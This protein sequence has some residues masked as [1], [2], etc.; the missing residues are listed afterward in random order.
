MNTSRLVVI[1]V[2]GLVGISVPGPGVLAQSTSTVMPGDGVT[3]Q[4]ITP[5]GRVITQSVSSDGRI[6]TQNITPTGMVLS[7]GVETDSKKTDRRSDAPS[8][9]KVGLDV[10]AWDASQRGPLL[11]VAPEAVIPAW[12]TVMRK[13]QFGPDGSPLPFT[14]V[15]SRPPELLSGG[16][17]RVPDLADYF[18]HRLVRLRGLSVLAPTKMVI[19]NTKFGKPDYFADLP[20]QGK[21]QMLQASLNAAQWRQ[22]GSESG[23]GASDLSRNQRELY[24]SFLPNPMVICTPGV[25][26]DKPI[27]LSGPQRNNIRLRL[28]RAVA[29]FSIPYQGGKDSLYISNDTAGTEHIAMNYDGLGNDGATIFG[30]PVK[31]TVPNRLKSQQIDFSSPALQSSISLTGLQTV[32]DMIA[33]IRMTT[34]I[35]IYVDG[36]LAKRTLWVRAVDSQTVRAGEALQAL[37]WSLTGA[38]RY[39]SDGNQSGVF[40]LTDDVEGVGSRLAKIKDWIQAAQEHLN[41]AQSTLMGSIR[42]RKPLQ[43]LGFAADDASALGEKANKAVEEGWKTTKERWRGAL[44]ALT[45][46]SPQ[47]QEMVRQGI[48]SY[49]KRHSGS[50][51]GVLVNNGTVSVSVQIRP[52]FLVPGVGVVSDL[53][54]VLD[55]DPLL[56]PATP[57]SPSANEPVPKFA[58]TITIPAN[59]AQG[60]IW[61]VS[62]TTED[63]VRQVI[64][65]AQKRG[66]TQVWLVLPLL[67]AVAND[68]ETFLV[69]SKALLTAAI[70][71]AQKAASPIKILAGVR[72]FRLPASSETT[73]IRKGQDVTITGELPSEMAKRRA[74]NY[75]SAEVDPRTASL[76]RQPAYDWIAPEA[77]EILGKITHRL[78]EVAA[79]PGV[80]GIILLDTAPPGY[81]LPTPSHASDGF[82][83]VGYTQ[84][85]RVAF[86]RSAGFDPIDITADPF[87]RNIRLRPSLLE[88]GNVRVSQNNSTPDSNG[89]WNR[90]RSDLLNRTLADMYTPLLASLP[91]REEGFPVYLQNLD[92][93]ST[94]TGWFSS[95]EKKEALP[96]RLS[97]KSGQSQ[98]VYPSARKVSSVSLMDIGYREEASLASSVDPANPA[99]RYGR[100]FNA[101]LSANKGDWAGVV[102]NFSDT[103]VTKALEVLE[104]FL[105]PNPRKRGDPRDR[106]CTSAWSCLSCPPVHGG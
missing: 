52:V 92:A 86:I 83:S 54:P 3:T 7:D 35:E 82:A 94:G 56:P 73:P 24:L 106:I 39:V 5:D 12:Q 11:A 99:T 33:R 8:T 9:L 51:D 63:E 81:S 78:S 59:L 55:V 46:L 57:I 91:K 70:T 23:L 27:V 4:L 47:Q 45:D 93:A 72:L 30:Q 96:R 41:Q 79:T 66:M 18:G 97:P 71:E 31:S 87:A 28:N 20:R 88:S 53:Q 32:G 80:S 2:L 102:F 10:A 26:G 43:Y 61:C 74:A 17:Y 16:H 60:G 98:N 21:L 85:S 105:S 89:E 103:P 42:E 67:P 1:T 22:L 50:G 76:T 15:P 38:I 49:E 44:V 64:Q 48:V 100:R 14:F 29:S 65:A 90:F 62:P 84:S 34:R 69:K 104:G 19:L 25:V 13:P 101:V 36:Q 95:W 75:L 6:I 58:D 40:I 77:R 37:C 68:S